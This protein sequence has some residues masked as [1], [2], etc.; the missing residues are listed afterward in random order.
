MGKSRIKI[1]IDGGKAS[2]APPLGPFLSSIKADVN[3]I[4]GEVNKKTADFEGMQVPVEIEV[5]TETKTANIIV[6]TPPV[7]SMIKKELKVEK[8]SKTAWKEQPVGDLKFDSAVKI[9]K[10]KIDAMNTSDLKSAVKQVVSTCISVGVTVEGKTPK[11]I[12]KEINSGQWD[13]RIQ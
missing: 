3:K 10:S 4:I 1:L 5:D 11:E 13:S 2:P 8:L 7:S 12:V 9:A 6:G